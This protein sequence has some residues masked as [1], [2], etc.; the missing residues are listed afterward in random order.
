MN[1]KVEALE[2]ASLHPAAAIGLAGIKGCLN[3]GADADFI[4]IDQV[5]FLI[6]LMNKI[7]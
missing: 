7:T 1:F 5:L 4:L 6:H 2:A 3:Y